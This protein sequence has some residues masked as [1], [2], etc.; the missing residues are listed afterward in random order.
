MRTNA[1]RPSECTRQERCLLCLGFLVSENT[2]DAMV[3]ASALVAFEVFGGFCESLFIVILVCMLAA[4]TCLSG[5]VGRRGWR[6]VLAATS[7]C[8]AVGLALTAAALC[9]ALP[10]KTKA[11]C[12]LGGSMLLGIHRAAYML[13]RFCALELGGVHVMGELFAAA[14]LGGVLGPQLLI[15]FG[16][17]RGLLIAAAAQLVVGT[18]AGVLATGKLDARSAARRRAASSWQTSSESDATGGGRSSLSS[19]FTSSEDRTRPRSPSPLATLR[20]SS[21]PALPMA[22]VGGVASYA[23]MLVVTVPAAAIAVGTFALSQT[24]AIRMLQIHDLLMNAPGPLVA[25]FIERCG[26]RAA[27]GL[28]LLVYAGCVGG[29]YVCG[30]MADVAFAPVWQRAFYGLVVVLAL[31]WSLIWLASSAALEKVAQATGSCERVA[32]IRSANEFLVYSACIAFLLVSLVS[33]GH[34]RDIIPTAAP[35]LALLFV[36]LVHAHRMATHPSGD[37]RRMIPQLSSD[38]SMK[39]SP[40]PVRDPRRFAT[41]SWGEDSESLDA[42]SETATPP[43]PIA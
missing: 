16:L 14:T 5:I 37:L 28:G 38:D 42:L 2:Q 9:A 27:V 26:T 3:A 1:Q 34:Y 33:R 40:S 24:E 21:D 35:I 22:L 8:G 25:A 6:G 7:V 12:A 19:W 18:A 13:Y 23:I 10:L 39:L 4:G 20:E 29:L 32:Q 36:T 41:D 30:D 17:A 43:P 15:S 11:A 31:G